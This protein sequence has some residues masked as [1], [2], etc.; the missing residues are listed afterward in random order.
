[1]PT[2][3]KPAEKQNRNTTENSTTDKNTGAENKH[4]N[5]GG[6][7]RRKKALSLKKV[8]SQRKTCF[9][10]AIW[11]ITISISS[12]TRSAAKT[13]FEVGEFLLKAKNKEGS[14]NYKKV[15]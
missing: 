11:F 3:I 1:V 6:W 2:I 15:L 10:K 8:R 9:N 14:Q 7:G 4:Y 12:N 13:Y 5:R